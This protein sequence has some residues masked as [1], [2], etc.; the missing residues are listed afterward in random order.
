[1]SKNNIEDI[2]KE[3]VECQVDAQQ[4]Q[5]PEV[6]E[7]TQVAEELSET[8][9]LAVEVAQ[10]Q[11]K[12]MRLAADFDNFRK[13]TLKEKMDLVEYAGEDV[14]KAMLSVVDDMDRAVVANEKV[15]DAAVIKEG[16][17]LIHHKMVETL[18]QKNVV[19]IDAIGQ[20]LDTDLHDAIAKFP[21]EQEDKKGYV[22][23][24]VEKGYKLKDKIVRFSKVV[25][26]E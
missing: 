26:G 6:E 10:W 22:I 2:E 23:D 18:K 25:V 16:M 14:I 4:Q 17:A 8:D 9:K 11:D 1:M 13:R 24:V 5:N 15:E 3:V 20:K 7:P 12:Y 19:E 21:V